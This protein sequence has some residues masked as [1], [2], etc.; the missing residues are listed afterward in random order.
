M[1]TGTVAAVVQ[2][3]QLLIDID[4][5]IALGPLS[6]LSLCTQVATST[7]LYAIDLSY[8]VSRI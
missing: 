3:I 1:F 5:G 7:A 2:E 8:A 4:G 6:A